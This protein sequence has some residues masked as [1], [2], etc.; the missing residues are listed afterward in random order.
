MLGI[1]LSMLVKLNKINEAENKVNVTLLDIDEL[2]SIIP[3]KDLE[4]NILPHDD[5]IINML[6]ASPHT[7]IFTEDFN[8]EGNSTIISVINLTDDELN[9]EKEK[10][11]KSANHEKKNLL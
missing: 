5:S 3:V 7:I 10:M 9:R 8:N 2:G 1:L 6:K 11:I 4:L